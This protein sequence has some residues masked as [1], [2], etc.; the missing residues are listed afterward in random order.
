MAILQ[1]FCN[2]ISLFSSLNY[3][4]TYEYAFW[5]EIFGCVNF[6]NLPYETIMNMPVHIRKFWIQKHNQT[7]DELEKRLNGNKDE[8][9][10]IVSGEGLNAYARQEQNSQR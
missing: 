5:N 8:G 1:P 2:L 9:T 10:S 4:D 7:A 3:N 6:L